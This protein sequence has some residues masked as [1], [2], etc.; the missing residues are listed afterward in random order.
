MNK[1]S[2]RV[3]SE[4]LRESVH[5]RGGLDGI[6]FSDFAGRTL[7]EHTDL[8]WLSSCKYA[9]ISNSDK[10]RHFHVCRFGT[11]NGTVAERS[12]DGT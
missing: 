11:E 2:V 5:R 6:Y 9:D 10:Y 4:S 1:A 12:A 7:L 3:I 8:G